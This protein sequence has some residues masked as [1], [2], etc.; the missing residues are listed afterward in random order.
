LFHDD[1]LEETDKQTNKH[2]KI[3]QNTTTTRTKN[4]LKRRETKSRE[5]T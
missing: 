2:N 3:K 4:R 5:M 1:S